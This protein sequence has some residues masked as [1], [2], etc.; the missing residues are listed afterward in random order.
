MFGEIFV[1]KYF[2]EAGGIIGAVLSGQI[3]AQMQSND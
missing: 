3:W 2:L 1:L